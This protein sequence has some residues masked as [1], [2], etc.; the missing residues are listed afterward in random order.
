MVMNANKERNEKDL[1]R[2]VIKVGE[3]LG[4]LAEAFLNV[5]SARNGK[6]KTW[7]DVREEACDVAIVALDI[8][9]TPTPDEA[10]AYTQYVAVLDI[11]ER[12]LI[13]WLA[14]KANKTTTDLPKGN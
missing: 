7:Q 11:F 10:N 2:R 3:E 9:L 13:K 14:T 8:A 1:P 12:K 5:S 4:E 6:G